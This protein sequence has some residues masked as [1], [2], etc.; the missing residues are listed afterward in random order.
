MQTQ[1]F[2]VPQNATR[3]YLGTHDGTGWFNNTGRLDV[4]VTAIPA[5]AVPLLQQGVALGMAALIAFAG[6]WRLRRS[7]KKRLQPSPTTW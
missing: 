7:D 4:T 5:V 3:L 6:S 2:A 1:I